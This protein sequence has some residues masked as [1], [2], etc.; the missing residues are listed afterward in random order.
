MTDV[1]PKNGPGS[2]DDSAKKEK[3]VVKKGSGPSDRG[4]G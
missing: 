2:G 4:K 1:G 3:M